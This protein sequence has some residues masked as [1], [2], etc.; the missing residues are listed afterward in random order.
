MA[1]K[2]NRQAVD[3]ARQLIGEGRVVLDDRDAWS[4]HQPTAEQEN[5]FIGAHGY[6]EY[7]KWHLGKDD[8]HPE[9]TKGHWKFPYGD[10]EAVHRCALLSAESRAGQYK[11]MDI[12]KTAHE[13]HGMLE[14]AKAKA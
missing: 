10:F 8:E 6:D 4:E 14:A 3:Y 5:E 11:Y 13:L 9:D 12:E 2:L 7:G 1:V